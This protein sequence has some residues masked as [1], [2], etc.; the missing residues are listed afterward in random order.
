MKGIFDCGEQ[1]MKMGLMGMRQLILS[2]GLVWMEV[3][4]LLKGLLPQVRGFLHYF[5]YVTTHMLN[6]FNVL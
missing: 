1:W 4:T 5:F 3:H 2:M 6:D